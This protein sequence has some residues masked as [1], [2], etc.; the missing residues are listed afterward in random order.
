MWNERPGWGREVTRGE[1]E[2]SQKTHGN[3]EEEFISKVAKCMQYLETLKLFSAYLLFKYNWASC[4]F[5]LIN[6]TTLVIRYVK[7][8]KYF[9][10]K[11]TTI[12]DDICGA[13]CQELW[14]NNFISMTVS[15]PVSIARGTDGL[16]W[17]FWKVFILT[18]PTQR[19]SAK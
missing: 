5:Y 12:T 4:T 2:V 14:V 1:R 8:R 18:T 9:K 11:I 15:A 16:T 13:L 7:S 19:K 6:L 3:L 10:K 17:L